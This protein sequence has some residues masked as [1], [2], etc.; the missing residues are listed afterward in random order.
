MLFDAG[1]DSK[2]GVE[3]V[4]L[5]KHVFGEEE[6]GNVFDVADETVFIYLRDPSRF[7]EDFQRAVDEL[8]EQLEALFK[9]TTDHLLAVDIKYFLQMLAY[10]RSDCLPYFRRYLVG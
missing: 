10:K 6:L 7:L 2:H 5:F 9:D 4:V 3:E 1:Q 8:R